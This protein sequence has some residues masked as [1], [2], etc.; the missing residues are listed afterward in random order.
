[1]AVVRSAAV[2]IQGQNAVITPSKPL[3]D[4][5]VDAAKDMPRNIT[6]SRPV[7]MVKCDPYVEYLVDGVLPKRGVAAIYGA[8]GSGKSFVAIDM[9]F[10]LASRRRDWFFLSLKPAGVM[11]VLLEGQAGL[12]KRVQAWELHNGCDLTDEVEIF[13]DPFRLDDPTD[14]VELAKEA[15]TTVGRGC[16]IV[17]DTLAQAMAGYDENSSAEM[18]AAIAGAQRLAAMVDGLVIL[19]HHTGKDPTKGMRGHS[20]LVGALDAAI[21]VKATAAGRLWAVRKSK[22]GEAGQEYGFELMRYTVGTDADGRSIDSCA[23]RQIVVS[24]SAS[25]PKVTGKHRV[26]VMVKVTAL[27][28]TG[29]MPMSMVQLIAAVTPDLDCPPKRRSTVAKATIDTL[30]LSGHLARNGDIASLPA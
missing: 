21:E 12:S 8:S 16:V 30:V 14:V 1:M 25:L 18:G 6:R 4:H 10:H 3:P 13:T 20:S 5:I 7:G 17:I 28:S 19:I 26:A 24:P 11:Y 22:D 23:V 2:C 29:Q 15:E 27:A 9:V